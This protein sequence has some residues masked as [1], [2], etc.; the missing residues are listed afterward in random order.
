MGTKFAVLGR[1][2]RQSLDKSVKIKTINGKDSNV[3]VRNVTHLEST[4]FC[5][6]DSKWQSTARCAS[7][8][9]SKTFA[10]YTAGLKQPVHCKEKRLYHG[11]TIHQKRRHSLA[12]RIQSQRLS[13]EESKNQKKTQVFATIQSISVA[14][15]KFYDKLIN[16][17]RYSSRAFWQEGSRGGCARVVLR[18]VNGA[19][20]ILF[21]VHVYIYS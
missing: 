14:A 6:N 10:Y 4:L 15:V 11:W 17:D 19:F 12:P 5:D 16:S 3:C 21:F 18:H 2:L 13:L 8:R 7:N 1:F 20:K 9:V